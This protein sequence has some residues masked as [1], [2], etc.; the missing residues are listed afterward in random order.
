MSVRLGLSRFGPITG[1][2]TQNNKENDYKKRLM[3]NAEPTVWV[4]LEV[5]IPSVVRNRISTELSKGLIGQRDKIQRREEKGMGRRR[6]KESIWRE[7]H[8]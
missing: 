6:K 4:C 5:D 8:S 3:V 2:L 7:Q 1:P